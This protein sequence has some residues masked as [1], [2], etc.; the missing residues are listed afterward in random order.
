MWVVEVAN[1]IDDQALDRDGIVP[2]SDEG[3]LGIVR[4]PFLH[5]SFQ[6][7]LANSAP[8]L[9]L[10]LMIG[11]RSGRELLAVLAVCTLT[12]GL[13]AWAASPA[14]TVVI[15]A[16][17]VVFGMLAFLLFRAFFLRSLGSMALAAAT[18][19]LY[20]GALGG[21]LPSG[22]PISWLDH[23]GGFVGG[24]GLA[25]TLPGRRRRSR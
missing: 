14:D 1:A 11:L 5:A 6:H 25:A 17:G 12:S 15:G 13:L 3:L 18:V 22:L 7:L 10:G 24:A 8:Y 9:V 4:A 21:L 20:G 16:S 19:A 2:R 23:L